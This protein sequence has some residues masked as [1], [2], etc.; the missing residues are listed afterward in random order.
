MALGEDNYAGAKQCARKSGALFAVDSTLATP[1]LQ[2]PLSLGADYVVHSATKFIGGHSDSL[3]GVVVTDRVDLY[4]AL[5][6]YRHDQGSVPG[7]LE[8]FLSLRGLRTLAVRLERSQATAAVLSERLGGI[9]SVV[10]VRYPGLTEHPQHDLAQR[11]MA[12]YGAMVSFETAGDAAD[13]EGVCDG[14]RLL[15]HGTSLGGVETMIERRARYPGDRE[16]G[17]PTTL[18]RMSVGLENVEDLWADLK[19]A[20]ELIDGGSAGG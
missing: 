6:A 12:G 19:Q 5:A 18:L 7:V 11:Q 20:L 3:L 9:R 2:R 1:L 10:R 15:V 4:E 8:T 17:I 13:A 16:Q 14:L